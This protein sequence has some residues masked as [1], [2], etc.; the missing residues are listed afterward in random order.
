[1]G[2][3]LLYLETLSTFY[4]LKTLA[5]T[6][7][8]LNTT[9]PTVTRRFHDLQ[10]QS[11]ILIFETRG[12]K[13]V[14]TEYGEALA[15]LAS[16]RLSGIS[17]D[18][19]SLANEYGKP[20]QLHITVGGRSELLR[21]HLAKLDI[22]SSLTLVAST[23]AAISAN[24]R[25]STYDVVVSQENIETSSYV[26]KKFIKERWF[27]VIP[28]KFGSFST[29]DKWRAHADRW[30]Y[31]CYDSDNRFLKGI[32]DGL[33]LKAPP[34]VRFEFSDWGSIAERIATGMNWGILPE[35]YLSASFLPIRENV[36]VIHLEQ[37]PPT[38]FFIYF[39][40]HLRKQPWLM[41]WLEKQKLS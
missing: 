18:V 33:G 22:P 11:S 38:I 39:K 29:V 20:S 14:L 37:V 7:E 27:L 31:A 25:S 1:M 23:S 2:I 12:R 32:V 36:Q 24:I 34:E 13:K 30:P 16:E 15:R 41:S 26:R 6:A 28:K 4:K 9:Q 19:K 10:N 5:K 21:T 3:P 40:T 8:A 17:T 35:S